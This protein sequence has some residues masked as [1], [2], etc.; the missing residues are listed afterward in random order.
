MHQTQF[1]PRDTHES[2]EGLP[3]DRRWCG[4]CFATIAL[5]WL[6]FR[7]INVGEGFYPRIDVGV[8]TGTSI[9]PNRRRRGHRNVNPGES[10]HRNVNPG[11]SR[12]ANVNH[13]EPDHVNVKPEERDPWDANRGGSPETPKA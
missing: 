9:P 13:G 7:R 2:V 4:L 6:A 10:C 3:S 12:H 1:R 5:P 8:D 11:E